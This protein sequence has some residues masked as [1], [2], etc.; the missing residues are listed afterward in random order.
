[1][2][3]LLS[4]HQCHN[5]GAVLQAY[6]LQQSITKLGYQ[7]EYIN[8]D[9]EVFH[10]HGKMA[11]HIAYR[12][13]YIN[14]VQLNKEISEQLKMRWHLFEDFIKEKIQTSDLV[15][16]E[17]SASV[18]LDQYRLL[19]VGGD[20]LWNR[21]LPVALDIY[22]IPYHT[23]IPKVSYG[24]SMGNT[25]HISLRKRMFLRH[26]VSIGVREKASVSYLEKY[27][28][29]PVMKNVDPVFLLKQ[30]EWH[31]LTKPVKKSGYIFAYVFN[32]G[33]TG[34]QELINNIKKLGQRFDQKV[35][36]CANDIIT[37]EGV[38]SV[39]DISPLQWVS[40]LEGADYVI[41]NS[42]HGMAFSLIFQ[43][44]FIVLDFDARKKELLQICGIEEKEKE[45]I[46][47]VSDGR[48]IFVDYK[49]VTRKLAKKIEE[50]RIY[51]ERI[52]ELENYGGRKTNL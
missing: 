19:I 44:Q 35:M 28:N 3:G 41:T 38:D 21:N 27:T 46:E 6:A 50:S 48:R 4:F 15:T 25:Q 30:D 43:K 18:L 52:C 14:G 5:Y 23:D 33:N 42:F 8:I 40:L 13:P 36:V 10:W 12:H 24:T 32:N 2:I 49:K 47:A 17:A 7:S 1:M 16:D 26:F 9:N 37:E 29:L 31:L 22:S 20:Q 34:F 39:I 45:T 11:G 51:L